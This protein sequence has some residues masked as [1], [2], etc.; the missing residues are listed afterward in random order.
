MDRIV[1]LKQLISYY[2]EF[3]ENHKFLNDFDYGDTSFIGNT[4]DM[5]FPYLWITHSASSEIQLNN[6]TQIPVMSLTFLVVDQVNNQKNTDNNNGYDSLNITDILSDCFQ[7]QQDL[8]NY[9]VT[10]LN[11]KGVFIENDKTATLDIVKDETKDTCYGWQMQLDLK[12][13]YSVCNLPINE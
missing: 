11:G 4:K 9:T 7:I 5:K 13:I 1:S 6:K 8:A 3:A 2:R 10:T 12:L